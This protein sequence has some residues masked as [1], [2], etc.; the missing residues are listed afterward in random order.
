MDRDSLKL[1]DAMNA[2]VIQYRGLYAQWSKRHGITY[3]ELLVLYTIR[4][5][6]YCTQKQI[7]ENYLLP[8]Q[9]INHVILELWERGILEL[10]PEHCVG[11]EKA[12][13]WTEEGRAYARPLLADLERVEEQTL[14]SF[15]CEQMRAMV[16]AMLAYGVTLQSVMAENG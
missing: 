13:V 5:Q 15:G 7:C 2:A 14:Q 6:G 11:R 9:T 16:Q 4:D 10:S 1:L 12:F 3:H 8:R